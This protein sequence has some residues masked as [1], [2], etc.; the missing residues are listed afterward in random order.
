MLTSYCPSSSLRSFRDA[1][2]NSAT[3]SGFMDHAS[4][5][6]GHTVFKSAFGIV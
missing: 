2:I 6:T 4:S 1:S 5:I 3:I